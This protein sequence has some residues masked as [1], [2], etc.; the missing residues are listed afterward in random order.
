MNRVGRNHH[1]SQISCRSQHHE[2]EIDSQSTEHLYRTSTVISKAIVF[3]QIKL[4]L[5][6]IIIHK[7]VT[8]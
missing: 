2:Q 4:F 3:Y 5:S 8:K 1:E 6:L 7:K